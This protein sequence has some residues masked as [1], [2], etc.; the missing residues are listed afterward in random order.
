MDSSTVIHTQVREL[1]NLIAC[2]HGVT[3][4]VIISL[5]QPSGKNILKAFVQPEENTQLNPQLIINHCLTES[6]CL[7]APDSV[8]FRKIPRTPSGKVPRQLLLN[9]CAC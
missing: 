7:R 9:S 3:D 1:E 4:V 8:I 2:I 6:T 5:N